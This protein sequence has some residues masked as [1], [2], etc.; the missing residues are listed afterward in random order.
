[1][2]RR[3]VELTGSE[4]IATIDTA[5]RD[6]PNRAFETLIRQNVLALTKAIKP[7]MTGEQVTYGVSNLEWLLRQSLK[8]RN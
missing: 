8:R 6:V 4:L 5:P 1:M 3:S 7:E 2:K